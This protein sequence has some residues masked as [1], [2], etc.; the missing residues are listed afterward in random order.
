VPHVNKGDNSALI[1]ER[2]SLSRQIAL[3]DEI[4]GI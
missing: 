1:S 2:Y 3:I 4:S